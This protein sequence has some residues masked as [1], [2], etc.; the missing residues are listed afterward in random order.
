MP[1]LKNLCRRN[2]L[3]FVTVSLAVCIG[4]AMQS[5]EAAILV[6]EESAETPNSTRLIPFP[7]AFA[8]PQFS[9]TERL[10]S[11]PNDH[12]HG[13]ALLQEPV[14]VAVADDIPVGILPVEE[15]APRLG[16]VPT[17]SAEAAA[18][19]LID[20]SLTAPCYANETVMFTHGDLTFHMR[21]PAEGPLKVQL[22]A[23]SETAEVSASFA[24]GDTV[25]ATTVVDSLA[26]Y[27]RVVISWFGRGGAELHA[28]E[29][30]AKYGA[31]GHVWR[32]QPR[33]VGALSGGEG[34]F[35]IQLGT[36]DL[37]IAGQAEVYTFPSGISNQVGDVEVSVEAEVTE[38]NCGK[39][40]KIK[41]GA[42]R[43]GRVT[44]QHELVLQM[45]DC[46]AIG[47]FLVLKNL[48]EDLTIA[49]K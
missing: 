39:P 18:G 41:S 6:N 35:L 46:S 14:L 30:G 31:S 11:L 21:M 48:V 12:G 26:F 28:R 10:P 19:A 47:E 44:D 33:D 2:V 1:N 34:G 29:F 5:S 49:R 38:V 25:I 27:D 15:T 42:L 40:L 9:T 16:C 13:I 8:L 32:G 43:Q 36:S 24:I 37:S 22:P 23:L 20:V 17:M 4:F 3:S 7:K 45:P